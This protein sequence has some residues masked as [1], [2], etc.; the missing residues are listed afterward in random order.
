MPSSTFPVTVLQNSVKVMYADGW[1]GAK[2]LASE[3]SPNGSGQP[4]PRAGPRQSLGGPGGER[5]VSIPSP[6]STQ[7]NSFPNHSHP[8]AP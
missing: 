8:C 1:N 2:R 5:E 6:D 7:V 3:C 4:R